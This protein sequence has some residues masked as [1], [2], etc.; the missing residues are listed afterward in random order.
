MWNP[1]VG[2]RWKGHTKE[3]D[4]VHF[5]SIT[6][7]LF[8]LTFIQKHHSTLHGR[9]VSLVER[10]TMFDGESL[11]NDYR[12]N[13][14]KSRLQWWQ[15]A[16]F[17]CEWSLLS[18]NQSLSDKVH[19]NNNNKFKNACNEVYWANIFSMLPRPGCLRVRYLISRVISCL[20]RPTGLLL[21]VI[22]KCCMW[23]GCI[24]WE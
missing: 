2:K 12:R 22:M 8:C 17:N 18:E 9:P 6:F 21:S 1:D 16:S 13:K 10:E 4:K 15:Q 3:L 7:V 24:K 5:I 20:R 11:L 19:N 14:W 23:Q